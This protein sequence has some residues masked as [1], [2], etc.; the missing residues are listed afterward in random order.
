M[1]FGV[2]C[3]DTCN[4]VR[5]SKGYGRRYKVNQAYPSAKSPIRFANL[6]TGQQIGPY[7]TDPVGEGVDL[8]L[9]IR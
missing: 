3:Y 5:A 4:K 6:T 7:Y 9:E 2:V 1:N 8:A